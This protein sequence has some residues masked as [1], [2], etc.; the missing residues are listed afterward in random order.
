MVEAGL[1][2]VGVH[3][4]Q[5]QILYVKNYIFISQFPSNR[6]K[7][8]NH[9]GEEQEG[10][11]ARSSQPQFLSQ[12]LIAGHT[13]VD[14]TFIRREKNLYAQSASIFIFVLLRKLHSTH[15][16]LYLYLRMYVAYIQSWVDPVG[17]MITKFDCQSIA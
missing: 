13:C 11:R 8:S 5:L 6:G 9:V 17:F 2:K 14:S 12:S 15:L 16:Y 7:K 1:L 4:S 3:E 10:C